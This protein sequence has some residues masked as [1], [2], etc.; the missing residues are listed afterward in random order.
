MNIS[1]KKKEMWNTAL[2]FENPEKLSGLKS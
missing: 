2:F 1:I